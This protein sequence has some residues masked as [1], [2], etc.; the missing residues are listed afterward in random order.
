MSPVLTLEK[1]PQL[2]KFSHPFLEELIKQIRLADTLGKFNYLA[3][4]LLIEQLI[5]LSEREIIASKNFNLETISQM[6]IYAF[7]QTIGVNIEKIT[8]HTTDTFINLKG[9][10]FSSAVISC[11][12]VIVLSSLIWGYK[13][14]RFLSLNELIEVAEINIRNAINKA[15]LY[16]DFVY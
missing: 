12:G 4:E 11:G 2:T 8:G 3:D 6:V 5:I 13:R 9:N 7:Y 1:P 10:E 14:F 16:L 15:S